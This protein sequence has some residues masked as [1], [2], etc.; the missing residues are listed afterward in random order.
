M[1]A[2]IENLLRAATSAGEVRSVLQALCAA[3]GPVVRTGVMVSKQDQP[4]R[5]LTCIV[6]MEDAV[7]GVIA[8]DLGAANLGNRLVVFKYEPPE[9]FHLHR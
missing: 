9:G 1:R 5:Q 7:A 2:E 4:S 3:H 8:G 6:E